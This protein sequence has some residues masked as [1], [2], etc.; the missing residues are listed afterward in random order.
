[1]SHAYD[2]RL[3]SIKDFSR[4]KGPAE[5]FIHPLIVLLA[6]KHSHNQDPSILPAFPASSPTNFLST[7]TKPSDAN[8][9]PTLLGLS[10]PTPP[11]VSTPSVLKGPNPPSMPQVLCRRGHASNCDS[12]KLPSASELAANGSSK[13]SASVASHHYSY[14]PLLRPYRFLLC[15]VRVPAVCS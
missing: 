5:L 10:G 12:P 6:H 4:G 15:S 3:N 8:S 9:T 14:S 13:G 1:M 11:K 2:A 7:S